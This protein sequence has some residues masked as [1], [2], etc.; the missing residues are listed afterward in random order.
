MSSPAKVRATGHGA[1]SARRARGGRA[2]GEAGAGL[3]SSWQRGGKAVLWPEEGD[4]L[5]T[6]DPW[7][8]VA[9]E[10]MAG[11][12]RGD[13]LGAALS[14]SSGRRSGQRKETLA[15][16]DAACRCMACGLRTGPA[17]SGGGPRRASARDA[18]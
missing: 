3:M 4:A 14:A 11:R 9:G 2:Q 16:D 8:R 15:A 10:L 12:A 1:G 13:K 6:D 17:S 5:A 7:Q 18:T